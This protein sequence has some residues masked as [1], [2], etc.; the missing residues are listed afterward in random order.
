MVELT[1]GETRIFICA[2]RGERLT[3][4]EVTYAVLEN[5]SYVVENE[6]CFSER[7]SENFFSV[8]GT[9]VS[10]RCFSN[11]D[12]LTGYEKVKVVTIRFCEGS[13]R[14]IENSA[15]ESLTSNTG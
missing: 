13:F 10:S 6:N 8:L 15:A 4:S 1:P 9:S 3:G 2:S 7:P 5:S 11:S 12:R 14:S